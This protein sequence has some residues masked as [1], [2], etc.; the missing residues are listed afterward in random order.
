M[1]YVGHVSCDAGWERFQ[2]REEATVTKETDINTGILFGKHGKNI[3]S[4][5][6]YA[7]SFIYGE[8]CQKLRQD[9]GISNTKTA[10]GKNRKKIKA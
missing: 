1:T 2:K 5:I 6:F 4:S 7:L 9:I 3:N 10:R 8:E